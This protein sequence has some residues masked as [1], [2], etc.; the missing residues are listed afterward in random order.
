MGTVVL[1]SDRAAGGLVA[2]IGEHPVSRRPKRGL[3]VTD[4]ARVR[5]NELLVS[6]VMARC[7]EIETVM[8]NSGERNLRS[9]PPAGRHC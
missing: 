6:R 9:K 1:Q 5:E 8:S 3:V 2:V 4:A 7:C